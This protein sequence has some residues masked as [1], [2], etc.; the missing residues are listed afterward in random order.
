MRRLTV[1][2]AVVAK[3]RE[4]TTPRPGAGDMLANGTWQAA[5]APNECVLGARYRVR[6]WARRLLAA[7][8]VVNVAVTLFPTIALSL[9]DLSHDVSLG[10]NS[11][12][13][14]R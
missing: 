14:V 8:V 5:L 3:T 12:C 9:A 11:Q 4:L 1:S 6:A 7:D 2:S 10:V 13:D